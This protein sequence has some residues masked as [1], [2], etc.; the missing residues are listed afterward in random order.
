MRPARAS[1]SPRRTPSDSLGCRGTRRRH[2]RGPRRGRHRPRRRPVATAPGSGPDATSW[3]R[4][5]AVATGDRQPAAGRRTGP[6]A[7]GADPVGV[8]GRGPTRGASSR[9]CSSARTWAP[10]PRRG[11]SATSGSATGQGRTLGARR[12]GDPI[13]PG[14]IL[15]ARAADRGPGGGARGRRERLRQDDD[16]RQARR[17]AGEPGQAGEHRRLGHLPRGGVGAA[18]VWAERAGAH[19]VRQARG[20]D[21]GRWRSTRSRRRRPG[22][23]RPDRRHRRPAAHEAAADGGAEE[24]PPG[25]REGRR[26]TARR[27]ATRPGRHDGSEWDRA[28]AGLHRG[29]GRDGRRAHEARRHGEGGSRPGGARPARGAGQGRRHR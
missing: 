24:G 1:W 13:D 8:R 14:S 27:D 21:P 19:L 7:R 11:S 22:V 2:R 20:A 10:R 6:G 18:R 28:G 4:T 12:R 25:D 29:G 5:G 3:P 15:A 9:G 26:P 16:D 23:G 17:P